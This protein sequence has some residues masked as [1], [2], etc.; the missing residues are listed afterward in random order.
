MKQIAAVELERFEALADLLDIVPA[1]DF[2]LRTWVRS[3]PRIQTTK[4]FGLIETQRACGFAGCAIGWAAHEGIIPG[5]ELSGG[6]VIF[7]RNDQKTLDSWNA[8][9]AAM[10]IQT[11]SFVQYLFYSD[12]YKT[13]PGPRVVA[14]RLRRFIGKIEAIR[15][16]DRRKI[17]APVQRKLELVA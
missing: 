5:L 3:L 12:S 13:E 9:M 10:G 4:L 17:A 11:Q 1:K 7:K 2:Y 6:T 14:K 8:V 15:A 16:R